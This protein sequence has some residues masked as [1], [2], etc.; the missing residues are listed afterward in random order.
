MLSYDFAVPRPEQADLEKLI[1]GLV[2]AGVEFI[3]IGGAAAV[4]HGA[5]TTTVDLDVVYRL[6]PDNLERLQGFLERLEA[7]FRDPA[8]RELSSTATH[9]AGGGQLLFLTTLGPLDVIGR[10]HDGRDYDQLM[11]HCEIVSDEGLQF[12]VLDLPTLIEVKTAAGRAKD[13]MVLP[14]LLALLEEREKS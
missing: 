7:V 2:S 5:P 10:L 14:I 1:E 3:V 8:G 9:L 12:P 11:A 4:L 6:T 13:R